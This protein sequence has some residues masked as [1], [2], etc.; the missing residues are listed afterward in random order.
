MIVEI[1]DEKQMERLGAS[2][3]EVVSSPVLIFL[4][5]D[6]GMGKTTFARGF[7]RYLGHQGNVKSPTY[8]LVEPYTVG[9]GMVY[10]FDLY[11]LCDPEELELMGIRDYL[12]DSISLLEWPGRG[13][14]VLPAPSVVLSFRESGSGRQVECEG[15]S[16]TLRLVE[17]RFSG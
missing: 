15:D 6:L 4:Q 14:G 16:A 9:G 3:A 2:F 1:P 7:I 10:H 8:T 11:R 17:E 13:A 5:G 12:Q